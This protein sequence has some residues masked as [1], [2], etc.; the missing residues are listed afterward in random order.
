[1]L[2]T[3]IKESEAQA[4]RGP[5]MKGLYS[6][7]DGSYQKVLKKELQVSVLDE[8]QEAVSLKYSCGRINIGQLYRQWKG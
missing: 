7:H 3:A 6:V 5:V 1:M 8:S 4:D 2:N